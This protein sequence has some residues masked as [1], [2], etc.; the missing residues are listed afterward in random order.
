MGGTQLSS[1]RLALDAAKTSP[2][3]IISCRDSAKRL[4]AYLAAEGLPLEPE[5]IR[6]FLAAE[7]NARPHARLPSTI[8]TFACTSAGS[9]PRARSR[10][11]PWSAHKRLV[12]GHRL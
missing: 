3:T 9:W 1:W 11:T 12:P 7:R 5:G 6:G 4:E 2:Q 8:A 10:K